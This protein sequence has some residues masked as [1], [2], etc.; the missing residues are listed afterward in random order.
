MLRLL[1]EN[2]L[3]LL[4]LVTAIGYPLGRIR[5]AGTSLGVASVLF[6]GLAVGAVDPALKL[7]EIVYLLG[8]VLFIYTVGLA[9][10]PSFFASLRRKGLRDNLL[11]GGVLVAAG[12]LTWLLGRWLRLETPLVAGL[13]CGGLTNTPALAAAIETLKLH[14]AT[15]DRATVGYSIAYPIG[16]IGPIVAIAIAQR[17]WHT[18]YAA[19]AGHLGSLALSHQPIEVRTVEVTNGEAAGTRLR[20]LASVYG[21][22]VVFTRVQRGRQLDL[23][24]ANTRFQVGDLVT[25]VGSPEELEQVTRVLGQVSL[26]HLEMDR[27]VLDYRRVFVSNRALAGRRLAELD[28]RRRYGAVITRLRRGDVDLVPRADTVLELGDRVRVIA[29]RERLDRISDFFGDSY[30]ALAEIDVMGFSL[31]LAFGLALGMIPIP[32]PG[33][34][35]LRLGFAGGP[36]V[37]GLLLG[38]RGFTGPIVWTVP[39]S[40]NLTLRQIGL[41][42]FLAGIGTRAGYSFLSTVSSAGGLHL[43][44]AGAAVTVLA[45]LLTL[46]V[47]HRLLRIPMSLLTGMVAGTQ[48]QPAV[49]GFAVEQSGNDLPHVGYATVYPLATIGKIL[50]VQLLLGA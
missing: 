17:L 44:V 38:A 31:G 27:S 6:A 14:G 15:G 34:A 43:L 21:W 7:P 39:Y 50:V 20:E 40:A 37:A 13:F 23:A 28:L 5:V 16:V 19:E 2:P 29:P 49:L 10:G 36:L 26:V 8:L 30:R 42:L 32:V 4:F 18:D 1:S 3:L 12:L 45:V 24:R 35:T 9:S 11:V 48:T 25:A 22:S 33:G 46:W 47:G 41:V